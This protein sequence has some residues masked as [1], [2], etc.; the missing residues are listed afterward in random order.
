M[1]HPDV[2]FIFP[3]NNKWTSEDISSRFKKKARN[4]YSRIDYSGS[5]TIQID[6]IRELKNQAKYAPYEAEKRFF[7]ISEADQMSRESANAFLKLLEEP[8]QSLIIILIT[9]DIN[10]LLDTIRSRCQ[11][12]YF[13]PLKFL[14]ALNIVKQF[15][16]VDTNLEKLIRISNSNL[17]VIFE[18]IDREIDDKRQQVYTYLRAVASG[19]PYLLMESVDNIVR[20]RDK[21]YLMEVLNLIT[22]WL[23]DA[24]HAINLASDAELINLDF[25]SELKNFVKAFA[26]SDFDTIFK[27]V[28]NAI[29]DVQRN[30]YPPLLLTVLGIRIKKN[31]IRT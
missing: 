20:I 26:K 13:A 30:I 23:R 28:E 27:D 18:N 1:N 11:K 16:E 22:L 19:N 24:L 8:P 12:I 15:S 5:T 7:I 31:L 2:Q 4:P 10:S 3:T 9:T 21:N 25:Q 17:K 6:R 29:L 14:D